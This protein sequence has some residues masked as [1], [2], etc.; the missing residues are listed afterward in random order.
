MERTSDK[1]NIL[2]DVSSDPSQSFEQVRSQV[3]EL[4]DSLDLPEL[5]RKVQDFGRNKP[6]TLAIAAL[7]VGVAAGLLMRNKST[8]TPF[9]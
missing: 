8:T 7:T 3:D 6:I 4:V 9:T 1:S 5:T 2:R